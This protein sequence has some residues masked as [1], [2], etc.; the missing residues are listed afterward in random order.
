MESLKGKKLFVAT[1]QYG[2]MNCGL[3]MKSCLDLQLLCTQYRVEVRFAFIF[4]ESLITRARNYL[5]SQFLDT[6]FTHFLFIDADVHFQPQDVLDLLIRDLDVAGGPYPK[7]SINFKNVALA[8]RKH[9]DLNPQELEKVVGDYVFNCVKGTERIKV[10]EPVEVLEIGTGFMMIRRDMFDK[11]K[12][13]YPTLR[14]KPDFIGQ[15]DFNPNK[16]IHIF[17]DTH[18]DAPDSLTGGG[19]YRYLSEDYFFCQL[20]RKMGGKVFLCPWMMTTHIGTYG[21]QGNMPA[22]ANL[23]GQL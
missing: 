11:F 10:G 2:G 12:D 23:T 7:K 3:F 19:T 8:A 17:F 21:F 4:N 20:V 15:S 13:A 1:P 14:F 6:D 18:V 16:W 22:I 9:P 5:V